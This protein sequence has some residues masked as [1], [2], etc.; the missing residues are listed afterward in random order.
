M[1]CILKS[2]TINAKGG[3]D[4]MRQLRELLELEK[5]HATSKPKSVQQTDKPR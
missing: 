2:F 3:A 5:Q 4:L 1:V